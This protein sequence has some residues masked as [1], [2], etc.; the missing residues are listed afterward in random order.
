ML[1]T[2]TS[3]DDDGVLLDPVLGRWLGL[4]PE[5]PAAHCLKGFTECP[6]A[7]PSRVGDLPGL[8]VG[9]GEPRS[10]PGGLYAKNVTIIQSA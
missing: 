9:V 3:Y 5:Q 1:A 7:A 10:R 6:R 2:L 4:T 8:W